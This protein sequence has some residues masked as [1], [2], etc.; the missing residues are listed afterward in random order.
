[1][2]KIFYLTVVVLLA[3]SHACTKT[4]VADHKPGVSLP[5][6]TNLTLEKI[7]PG[8]ARI[9]WQMPGTIPEEI[10]QPVSVV[11]QL[12]E[13]ISVMKSVTVSTV[14]LPDAP[15]THTIDLPKPASTYHITV[16]LFGQTKNTDKNFSANIY[17]T[18]QTVEYKK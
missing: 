13:I 10:Q 9:S 1:M 6:V 18:G 12:Q 15:V 14:T 7:D 5:P 17:S 11:V 2:K 4:S 3:L 8:K 16:K